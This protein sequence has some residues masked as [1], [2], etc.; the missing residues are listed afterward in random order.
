MRSFGLGTLV[1]IVAMT[2]A[3]DALAAE[4]AYAVDPDRTEVRFGVVNSGFA[5]TSGTI[6]VR[7]G[8]L[9]IDPDAPQNARIE[10]ILE[11]GSID[12]GL[13][14]RDAAIRSTSLLDT[15]HYPTIRF[16]TRRVLPDRKRSAMVIGD[17]TMR[18]V[19]KPVTVDVDLT[20]DPEDGSTVRFDGRCRL[21]RRDWGMTG[22]APL[23][24][25]EV[26]I[27]FRLLAVPSS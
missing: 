9:T 19:A 21:D 23:V 11:A 13:A 6:R 5:D 18:D 1:T 25:D 16:D 7:S 12:T 26:T 22:F 15:E 2:L 27:E 3:A 17:L 10:L 4:R 8:R 14:V 20:S 24:G